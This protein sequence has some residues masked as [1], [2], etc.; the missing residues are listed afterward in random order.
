MADQ[1]HEF[2]E[3]GVAFALLCIVVF[4]GRAFGQQSLTVTSPANGARVVPGQA[5]TVQVSTAPNTSFTAVQ[6][7][8]EDIGVTAP[9]ISAPYTFTLTIPTNVVGQKNLTALGILSRENGVFSPTVMI[10]SETTA[11]ATGLNLNLSQINF[12]HPGQQLSL[13]VIGTFDDGSNLD[14]TRSSI[15]SYVSGDNTVAAAGPNG[16]VTAVGSGTTTVTVSYGSQSSQVQIFVPKSIRGDLNGDGQ[17]NQDDL[18]IILAALNRPATAATDARDLNGDGIIDI[19]DANI[20]ITLCTQPGCSLSLFDATPPTSTAMVSPQPNSAEWNNSDVTVNLI[21]IDNPDGSGLKQLTY[22]TSGAQ[23]V[24]TTTVQGAT[25]SFTISAEGTTTITFFGTDNAGN[26]EAAKTLT[27]RIDKTPPSITGSR[28]PAPNGNGWNNSAV[29]AS[30]QCA[31]AV[32][33]LA[34]GSPPAPTLLSAE[35]AGQ[36]V[37]G[38]CQDLAG[39]A[40]TATVSG[41]NIDTKP[42]TIVAA[43]SPAPNANGWNKT[44]VTVS[45]TCMDSL[46]GLAAG[47]PP[48]PTVLSSEGAGQSV[49]G[50]CTDLAGNSATSTA[51]RINIDKTSP[52]I[53]VSASPS[54]LWPPDGKMIPVTIS[55]RMTDNLSGVNSSTAAFTVNDSYG[56]VQ[57]SGPVSP[58]SDGTYSFTISLEAGRD[59]QD[60]SG[61]LYTITVSA[62]DNAGNPSSSTAMVIVPHDQGQ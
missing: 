7:I 61:R 1:R 50:T 9:Q 51:N 49:S 4:I 40:A 39:N 48:A 8:G 30:F 13:D 6:V 17:V 19:L 32:S 41:I 57:P 58:A 21:S 12:Q 53:T 38:T 16:V 42:P 60:K 54:T 5:I 46:S 24:S 28:A 56:L 62:Q 14:I 55:G 26:I 47:S 36:S 23:S 25:A 29:T 18:N 27:I 20:L 33:G 44:D 34:A 35:G 15:I 45:F 43:R 2:S 59:G 3:S 11:N 37:T 22:A 31:D 10:D 52:V